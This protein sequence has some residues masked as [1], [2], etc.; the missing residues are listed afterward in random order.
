MI[1]KIPLKSYNLNQMGFYLSNYFWR[2]K[3]WA[4]YRK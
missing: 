4:L 3:R 1:Q 2:C